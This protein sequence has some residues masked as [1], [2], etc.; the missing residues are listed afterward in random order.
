MT[1]TKKWRKLERLVASIENHLKPQGAVVKYSH[2]RRDIHGRLREVDATIEYKIGSVPILIIVECRDRKGKQGVGWIEQL[3]TKRENL[4]ANQVVAVSTSGFSK[5]AMDLAK[6]KSIQLRLISE[7]SDKTVVGWT[8]HIE[9]KAVQEARRVKDFNLKIYDDPTD[10]FE[11]PREVKEN[12]KNNQFSIGVFTRRLDNL[13]VTLQMLFDAARQRFA[14][15][16]KAVNEDYKKALL[17]GEPFVESLTMNFPRGEYFVAIDDG[18]MD[19]KSIEIFNDVTFDLHEQ[20]PLDPV[21]RYSDVLG[22]EIDNLAIVEY[23]DMTFH[24]RSNEITEEE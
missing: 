23:G 13:E 4:G 24:F 15:D 6:K 20:V 18:K 2:K 14:S 8:K 22:K 10:S 11:L 5:P 9:V 21:V 1:Q 12:L 17:N 19:I 7:I 3:V 16:P